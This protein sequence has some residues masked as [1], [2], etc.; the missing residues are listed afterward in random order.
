MTSFYYYDQN[1]SAFCF[2][3]QIRAFVIQTSLGLQ[4]LNEKDS[5]RSKM[6][7]LCK[8]PVGTRVQNAKRLPQCQEWRGRIF[9]LF[10]SPSPSQCALTSV[11]GSRISSL[12]LSNILFASQAL[13][14]HERLMKRWEVMPDAK[15]NSQFYGPKMREKK[16]I[17]IYSRK[18]CWASRLI[19]WLS[20]KNFSQVKYDQRVRPN[21][22]YVSIP[23]K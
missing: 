17:S 22:Q 3:V 12:S 20:S 5:G 2:L 13:V 6:T 11:F 23:L 8:W 9:S 21:E 10:P 15:A 4:N 14:F 19:S 16:R 18:K 1:P 7:P